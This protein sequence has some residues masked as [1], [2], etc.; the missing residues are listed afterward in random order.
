M[1]GQWSK[2]AGPQSHVLKLTILGAVWY[3]I[4]CFQGP[5]EA[6]RSMQAL[7]HFSDYNVGHAHSAVFAV[8][9]I[10]AVA[11]GHLCVPRASGRRLWSDRLATWTYWCEILGF[12]LMFAVLSISGLQQGAMQQ[13]GQASFIETVDAIRPYWYARTVGGTIMDV[14]LA[15]FAINMAMTAKRGRKAADAPQAAY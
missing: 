14:G 1:R 9:A 7:T 11:A 6:L 15:L 2:F 10:W 8:F 5:T 3:L 13:H 12:T 4:T